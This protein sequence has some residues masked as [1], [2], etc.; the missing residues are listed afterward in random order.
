MGGK[1]K[2][3][4]PQQPKGK[5]EKTAPPPQTDRRENEAKSKGAQAA[6]RPPQTKRQ[7]AQRPAKVERSVP[8]GKGKKEDEESK[9][10]KK[11]K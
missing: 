1:K 3:D 9:G 10:K 11:S 8:E 6:P 5:S 2:T 7:P 4:A